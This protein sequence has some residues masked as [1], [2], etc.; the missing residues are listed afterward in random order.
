MLTHS[1]GGLRL[2]QS[3]SGSSRE[4]DKSAEIQISEEIPK[5][6]GA[7]VHNCTHAFFSRKLRDD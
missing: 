7:T 3:H 5:V 1:N 2:L 6:T 4:T